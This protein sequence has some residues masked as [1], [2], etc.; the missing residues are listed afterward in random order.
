MPKKSGSTKITP[1][2]VNTNPWIAT[3]PAT[4]ASGKT[5]L[6]KSAKPAGKAKPKK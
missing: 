3:A 6:A 2:S 4:G 5:S 1:K